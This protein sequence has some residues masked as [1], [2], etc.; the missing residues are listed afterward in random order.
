MRKFLIS[1]ALIL[2]FCSELEAQNH[3]STSGNHIWFDKP[4]TLDG[5]EVWKRTK[6]SV[7]NP[8]SEWEQYSLPIG[9]GS[10]G[11]NVFGSVAADR[12]TLNEKSLWR[13]G[14]NTAKGPDYY[15]D[16]NK[17]SAHLLQDIR[18]AFV[19][20]DKEKA[21]KLTR[22][23]F[24]GY[25]T[26]DAPYED[27]YR[28]GSYTTF[29]EMYIETGLS[30]VFMDNYRRSLSLDSALVNISFDKDGTHYKRTYFSSYPDNAIVV[31]YS[32]DKPGKQNLKLSYTPNPDSKGAFSSNAENHLLYSG[33][34][35]D[36]HQ[37]FSFEVICEAVG[38]K[39]VKSDKSLTI[40]GADEV[41]FLIAGATDYKMNY[42]PDFSDRLT[43]VGESPEIK[44]ARTLR[45]IQSKSYNQLLSSHL[46]DYQT[47]FNRLKLDLGADMKLNAIPTDK[48]LARYKSGGSDKGL[49]ELYYQFGRYLLIASSRKGSLP[50]NLQGMWHNNVDGAWHIDYHNNINIQMNYWPVSS[51][52]MNECAQPLFDYIKT[53]VKPGT[54][55]AQSYFNA[56]GW[57]ASISSNIYGFTAPFSSQD[58]SWNLNPVAGP[59]LATHLWDYYDYTRDKKFLKDEAYELIKSSANFAVDYLWKNPKGI[60][61]AAPST[62]P[63]HGP[64]S[65]GATYSHA[66]IKEILLNAIDA[67]KVLG[68]DRKNRAEWENVL[69]KIA[70]YEIGR[71]G[72]LMEWSEDIDD[73]ESQH[74]HVNHLFGLHP[75]HTISPILTP[76]LAEASKVVLKHRGDFA[77]G[78]SMG[79]KLNQWAR[80]HDG[81][82]A[83]VLYGNLLK[84][85]TLP[86]L[87]DSHPPFQIDG[88]FGGT[89]GITEMLLQSHMGFI[90]ILPALPK[91]WSNGSVSGLLAR[92]NFEIAIAWKNQNLSELTVQSNVGGVCHL[93][94]EGKDFKFNTTKG[95]SYK[96][97]LEDGKMKLTSL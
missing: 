50:A 41:V 34:L 95:K 14:P 68:V 94:Y 78:W 6:Q 97:V 37:K 43:Y 58:M 49:E 60:Y 81:D 25:A 46:N 56:R 72:Q 82:H 80:L 62:S 52:N 30:D 31:K 83:Y 84:Q 89:A 90:H 26:Y 87:W 69:K 96:V 73:P 7:I 63:E 28:Y 32:A 66:V 79:W 15:W 17:K 86:N 12:V 67:S 8:D 22:E 16:V 11:G 77:T 92:G 2:A 10:F 35:I 1:I 44:T 18:R 5:R 45:L 61:T 64:I 54:I 85:G 57:T 65:Q 13:G 75:G 55:T 91:A 51:T 19:D 93:Y 71:Y 74:R 38:G 23:N 47:I 21:A 40:E 39:I 9:N 20:G 4:T 42:N 24:N 3:L 76:E 29:G 36:N 70:P 33:E 48:R 27:S 53:L 59:W 88:N